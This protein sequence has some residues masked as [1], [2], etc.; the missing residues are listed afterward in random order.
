MERS[1]TVWEKGER[2][3]SFSSSAYLPQTSQ[4]SLPVRRASVPTAQGPLPPSEV[5][6]K[7]PSPVTIRSCSAIRFRS[8]TALEIF[9]YSC[10][11]RVS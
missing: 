6:S 1:S 5:R 9:C 4:A 11:V 8:E 2:V 10:R 3:F 7:Q